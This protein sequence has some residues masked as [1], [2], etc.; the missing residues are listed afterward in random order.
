MKLLIC[1]SKAPTLKKSTV[2][3]GTFGNCTNTNSVLK[4]FPDD[5]HMAFVIGGKSRDKYPF[6]VTTNP[7]VYRLKCVES[8]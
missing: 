4:N 5:I 7:M 2:S 8:V 6:F 1:A 3:I